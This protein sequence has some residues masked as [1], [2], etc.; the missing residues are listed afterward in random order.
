MIPPPLML[1]TH[2][3]FR[4]QNFSETRKVSPT[5]FFGT[6]RQKFSTENRDTPLIHEIFRYQK[7]LVKQKGSPTKFFITVRQKNFDGKSW[8][9]PPLLSFLCMKNFDARFF[10][11]QWRVPLRN[12]SVLWDKKFSTENRDT[13]SVGQTVGISGKLMFLENFWKLDSKQ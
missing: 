2:E 13:R 1:L 8:D 3:I 5:N 7:F 6:V 4:Y 11:K 9:P 10:L 12:F